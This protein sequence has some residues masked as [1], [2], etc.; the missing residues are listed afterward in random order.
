NPTEA[1]K[2]DRV[3]ELK[4]RIDPLQPGVV[5]T[6]DQVVAPLAGEIQTAG[7]LAGK[8]IYIR[9]QKHVSNTTWDGRFYTYDVSTPVNHRVSFWL[10]CWRDGRRVILPD[11]DFANSVTPA[12]GKPVTGFVGLA[13]WES[14]DRAG[15]N[16]TTWTWGLNLDAGLFSKNGMLDN[17]FADMTH[18][19]STWGRVSTWNPQPGEQLTLLMIRGD[20]E[21]LSSE[22]LEGRTNAPP[23]DLLLKLKARVDAVPESETQEAP[24]SSTTIPPV[25]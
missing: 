1:R 16:K 5:S 15:T 2:A 23:S 7:R 18:R 19:D 24:Q 20:K 10:E 11:F 14:P 8:G 21:R 17:P 25:Q 9:E 4:M 13:M 3:I 6:T 12:R 22:E